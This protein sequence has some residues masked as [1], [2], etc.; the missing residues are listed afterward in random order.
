MP[1]P[2]VAPKIPKVDTLHGDIRQDDYF[3]LRE[4]DNPDVLAYLRAENAYTDE[5]LG[6]TKAFQESLYQEMLARIK[7]DDSSVP[8]RRGGHFYY[9]RTEKG[10]QYPIYCRKAGSLDAPE[11]I[12]LDLNALAEGHPFFSL[13]MS[14]V[15]DDGNLVAYTTD[16]TGFREYTLYVKDLRTGIVLPRT[17]E[18]VSSVA[19]CADDMTLFYVTED[20]AKRPYRLWCYRPGI[21][22]NDLVHEEP[23]ALFRIGVERSRSRK[24]LFLGTG[25]FTTS[26]WRYLPAHDPAGVWQM[27]M[28]REKDHEYAVDHG[29]G[30]GATASTSAPTA[31]AGATSAWSRPP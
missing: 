31:A 16:I 4:K 26:E 17:F 28:P 3:W 19:W 1:H 23:D 24:Y 27:L 10:K 9:S 12:T 21:M 14:T 18:R 29:N 13:G 2:P 30:G 20:E 15:S 22:G 25:S 6:E 5:V 11:E 8:Y 7:E